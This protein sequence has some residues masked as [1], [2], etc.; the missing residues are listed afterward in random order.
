MGHNSTAILFQH[1]RELVRPKAAE[2]YWSIYPNA[3][4]KII[5]GPTDED[6][7]ATA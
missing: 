1:Y 7:R 4:S 6:H 5:P 3:A 2:A